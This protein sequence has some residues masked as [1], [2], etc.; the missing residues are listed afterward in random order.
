M[1]AVK[2]SQRV[3]RIDAMVYTL[4]EGMGFLSKFLSALAFVITE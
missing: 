1:A 3:L 4:R 2:A